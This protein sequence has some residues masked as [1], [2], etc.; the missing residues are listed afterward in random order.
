MKWY[1]SI[2]RKGD[3]MGRTIGFPT[4]NLNPDILENTIQQG[5]Y[6]STV[7][8][9]NHQYNGAL[10]FGPRLIMHETKNVLEIYILDFNKEIYGEKVIFRIGKF[11]RPIANFSSFEEMKKQLEKD[12]EM[13]RH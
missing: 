9:K 8:Y 1:T 2:V 12:V 6:K 3:Q 4:V 13:I 10:Y 5:I 7:M 11:I